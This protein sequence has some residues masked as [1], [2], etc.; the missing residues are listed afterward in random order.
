MLT[1]WIAYVTLAT[2][3]LVAAARLLERAV[4]RGRRWLWGTV[5]VVAPLVPLLG[6][7]LQRVVPRDVGLDVVFGPVAPVWG[8]ALG[9]LES[10]VGSSPV[11]ALEGAL[12]GAWVAASVLLVAFLVHGVVRIRRLRGTW[13]RVEVD[14][15]PVL[16]SREFGPAVVGLRRPEIV[17]PRWVLDLPAEERA[18]VLAHEEEHRRR[19]DPGLLATP[20]PRRCAGRRPRCPRRPAR[21]AP[22]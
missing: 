10:A 15:I 4:P 6:I 19:G 18:L 5:M 9:Q 11:V 13:S 17:V 12:V 14:G 2:A 1:V 22:A 20:A 21:R 7:V 16:L 8:A 3:L